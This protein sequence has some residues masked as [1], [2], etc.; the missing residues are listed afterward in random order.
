MPSASIIS[1]FQRSSSNS[2]LSSSLLLAACQQPYDINDL[3]YCFDQQ[4][5]LSSPPPSLL[6]D[7]MGKKS[8]NMTECVPVPSSEHVAEIVGRQGCK[9][10]ALRTKTNTY[11]KTPVRGDQ[12]LFIITGRKEDVYQ[13]KKEILSAAEH[14]SQIRAARK[15]NSS[16]TSSNSSTSSGSNTNLHYNSLIYPSSTL[17][18]L[19]Q[20]TIQVRVPY[21]VVGLVVGPKGATIKRIQQTT[22]TYIVTPGRDKE[23]VFEIAGLPENVEA[24]RIEIESHIAARTGQTSDIEENDFEKDLYSIADIVDTNQQCSK[25]IK[26]N[27]PSSTT[28]FSHHLSLPIAQDDKIKSTYRTVSQ[29]SFFPSL[30]DQLDLNSSFEENFDSI[31]PNFNFISMKTSMGFA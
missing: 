6:Y 10:K 13:A 3:S 23:P 4:Q 16:S 24:A 7:S 22:N 28:K 1:D 5:K 9:I 17:N 26:L 11:I 19:Q 14:F 2:S 29:S 21:R 31:W 15:Q 18:N 27:N 12:P 25:W 8:Q 30:N 20:I